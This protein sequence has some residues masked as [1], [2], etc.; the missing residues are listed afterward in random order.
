MSLNH[1]QYALKAWMAN[2]IM[3]VSLIAIGCGAAYFIFNSSTVSEAVTVVRVEY[4]LLGVWC[5]LVLLVNQLRTKFNLF[6]AVI[7]VLWIG[8]LFYNYGF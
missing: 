3:F 7:E 6:W 2:L 4:A 1:G 8:Y 5:L